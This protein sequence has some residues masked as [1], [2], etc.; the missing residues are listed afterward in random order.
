MTV[1]RYE[2]WA[3]LNRLHREFDQTF[4]PQA[5][6]ATWSPAVD[7]HEE[8]ERFLAASEEAAAED[9]LATQVALH[10]ARGRAWAARGDP[11]KPTW[12]ARTAPRPSA[13][14]CT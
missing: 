13:A 14:C 3:L 6:D 8:A 2:P 9:D 10:G 5:R 12:L 7:V 11:V 1:V 4:E